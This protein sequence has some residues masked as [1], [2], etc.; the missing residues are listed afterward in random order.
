MIFDP[1]LVDRIRATV[2][3]HKATIT[4]QAEHSMCD[5]L[6][7]EA[8]ERID[9]LEKKVD[10]LEERVAIMSEDMYKSS[11]IRFP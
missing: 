6:L 9:Y 11:E 5:I 3:N 10:E 4:G 7:M 1:H 8:A 2:T